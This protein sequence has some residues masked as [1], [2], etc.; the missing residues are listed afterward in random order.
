MI[1]SC[2]SIA[3]SSS[4]SSSDADGW[5]FWTLEGEINQKGFFMNEVQPCWIRWV[6]PAEWG[7]DTWTWWEGSWCVP[8]AGSVPPAPLGWEAPPGPTLRSAP[9]SELCPAWTAACRTDTQRNAAVGWIWYFCK[10]LLIITEVESLRVIL[11]PLS[12]EFCSYV[13]F[14]SFRTVSTVV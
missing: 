3:E 6:L 11:S 13:F 9:G 10:I 2:S 4:L 1:L 8:P 7:E 5:M 14:V 12:W